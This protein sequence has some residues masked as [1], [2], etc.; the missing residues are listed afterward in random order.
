MVEITAGAEIHQNYAIISGQLADGRGWNVHSP[1]RWHHHRWQCQLRHC[2]RFGSESPS[3]CS[4]AGPD[5]ASLSHG[6]A[7]WQRAAA[8]AAPP[9]PRAAAP[10]PGHRGHTPPPLRCQL[11]CQCQTCQCGPGGLYYLK[12]GQAGRGLGWLH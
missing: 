2:Q 7:A 6:A 11:H 4:P 12:H 5:S 8:A 9:P 1:S 10:A 3:Q